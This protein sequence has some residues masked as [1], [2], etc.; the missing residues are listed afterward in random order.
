MQTVKELLTFVVAGITIGSVIAIL[1]LA[2]NNLAQ[3]LFG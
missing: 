3:T 1:L 2:G